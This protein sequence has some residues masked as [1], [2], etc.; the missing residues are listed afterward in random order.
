MTGYGRRSGRMF[1]AVFALILTHVLAASP[2]TASFELNINPGSGLAG[3]T[4]ALAH[5]TAPP[6]CGPAHHR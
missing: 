3:H 6:P 4:A 5:S 1:A 2:A